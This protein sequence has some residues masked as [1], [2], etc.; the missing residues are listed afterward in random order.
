MSA[1]T[2]VTHEKVAELFAL[3]MTGAE[4]ARK[5]HCGQATIYLRMRKARR[6]DPEIVRRDLEQR[7]CECGQRKRPSA[8]K[9]A[10]CLYGK[11]RPQSKPW[12]SGE[13]VQQDL[14]LAE[15][16]PEAAEQP[17]VAGQPEVNVR[18]Q[19][20]RR[21]KAAKAHGCILCQGTSEELD[22]LMAAERGI[23]VEEMRR[24]LDE[25]LK[26]DRTAGVA[27]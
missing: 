8:A 20:G 6:S 10:Y 11:W 18:C 9:C 23:S 22:Q 16:K 27:A 17:E 5:L 21:P 14:R 12:Y 1:C 3:G 24:L 2:Q 25:D 26:E 19:C 4:I 13:A 7:T 15:E